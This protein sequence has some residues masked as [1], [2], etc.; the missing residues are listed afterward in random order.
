MRPGAFEH[1]AKNR[2]VVR[3]GP[4]AGKHQLF[5]FAAEQSSHLTPGSFQM[6]FRYLAILV[7]A[8]GVAGH[9]K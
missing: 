5:G 1:G 3:F 7:N 8:G 6:L 4:A 2:E 9:F